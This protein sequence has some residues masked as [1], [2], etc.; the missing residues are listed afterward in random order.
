MFRIAIVN[1]PNRGIGKESGS[2]ASALVLQ[3]YAQDV[4]KDLTPVK[5]QMHVPG[6]VSG[7]IG[8]EAGLS[9]KRKI[10]LRYILLK[11]NYFSSALR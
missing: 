9:R 4:R 3:S 11:N 5:Q 10:S 8:M 7:S 2:L 6:L 1:E